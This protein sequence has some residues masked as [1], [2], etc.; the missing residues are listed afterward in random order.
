ML[1]SDLTL[2]KKVAAEAGEIALHYFRADPKVWEK[3]ENAGPVTEADLAVNAHFEARLRTARPDYGWLSEE[4]E[5]DAARLATKRQFIIDPIDGTRAFIQGNENWAMSLAV[6]ENGRPITAVVE[7]PKKGTTFYAEAG[8]GAFLNGAPMRVTAANTL[9]GSTVLTAKFNMEPQFWAAGKPPG[10]NRQFRSSLAYR[11]AAVA[12]GRFDAMLTLRPTWEWDIAAGSLI[13]EEAGGMAVD[14][15]GQPHLFNHSK[16][17]A[18]G[19][20]AGGKI[21]KKLLPKLA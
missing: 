5:D 14:R 1:E 11:L 20:L 18:D 8:R 16:P 7:M 21:V 15:S 2:L 13:V 6:V 10:F 19:I 9:G 17:M 4:T 12:H 3:S